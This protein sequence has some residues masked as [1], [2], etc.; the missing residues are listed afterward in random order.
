MSS[1]THLLEVAVA[2]A[3]A[4]GVALIV[5]LS[6]PQSA[7]RDVV[8]NAVL[9]LICIAYVLCPIDPLPEIVLGPVGF[10]DDL[11]VAV[12]GVVTAKRAASS[13]KELI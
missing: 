13:L 3:T 2:C 7:M 1:I 5:A 6:M 10:V 11:G 12:A 4:L 8:K 9:T